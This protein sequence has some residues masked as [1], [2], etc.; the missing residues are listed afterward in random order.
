MNCVSLSSK[1]EELRMTR[2][3][4]LFAYAGG[5]TKLL[6][7]YYPFFQG[8][9]PEHCVDYFGGSGGMTA[10]F[11]HLYPEAKLYLNEVDPALYKLFKCIQEEYAEFRECLEYIEGTNSRWDGVAV[12]KELYNL[13]RNGHNNIY[14]WRYMSEGRT[15]EEARDAEADMLME[16]F[17]ISRQ[18]I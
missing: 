13:I 11:H 9:R 5:K 15:E 6:K 2:S 1:G 18:D 4:P 17:G 12:K 7:L 14:Y 3:K 10:W 16:H 8:L